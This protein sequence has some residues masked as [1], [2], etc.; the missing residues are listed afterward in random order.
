[1]SVEEIFAAHGQVEQ[2]LLDDDL[3]N[4]LQ[5][6]GITQKHVVSFKEILEIANRQPEYFANLPREGRRALIVMVRPTLENRF[7]CVPLEPAGRPGIW[8]AVTAFTANSH[9]VLRY[10]QTRRT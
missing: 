3:F 8:R 5:E 1:M 4:H 2:I 9:H 10:E 6:R 7:L